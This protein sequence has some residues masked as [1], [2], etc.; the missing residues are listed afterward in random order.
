MNY[1]ALSAGIAIV[2]V[3]C[4][5]LGWLLRDE[6]QRERERVRRV[7][8]RINAALR[9]EEWREWEERERRFEEESG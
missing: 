4:G 9:R 3:V 5:W 1:L 8:A 6:A 2:G 7:R